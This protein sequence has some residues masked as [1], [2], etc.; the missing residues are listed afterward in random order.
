MRASSPRP[1]T[2]AGGYRQIARALCV[3]A[4]REPAIIGR[5]QPRALRPIRYPPER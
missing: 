4:N 2:A 5:Q 3:T 1:A